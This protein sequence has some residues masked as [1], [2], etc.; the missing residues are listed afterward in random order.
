M[1]TAFRAPATAPRPLSP[2]LAKH[3]PGT[4]SGASC[5]AM[6]AMA[7]GARRQRAACARGEAQGERGRT[8]LRRRAAWPP[9][10]P[11]TCH[12]P[13][14]VPH[15]TRLAFCGRA[16]AVEGSEGTGGGGRLGAEG[17]GVRREV[18]CPPDRSTRPRLR[19]LP[20]P[21]P[22]HTELVLLGR[23]RGAGVGGGFGRGPH[24]H[25][26]AR[27]QV[28]HS[29][30]PARIQGRHRHGALEN[31]QLADGLGPSVELARRLQ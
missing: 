21:F 14:S 16:G 28:P 9:Q 5:M 4:S 8:H 23:G 27:I 10:T 24:S 11:S 26:P 2:A 20:S 7:E 29:H 25:A 15:Q 1:C 18:F 22:A 31:E 13:P 17:R 12:Q 6:V 19:L 3:A 30:A